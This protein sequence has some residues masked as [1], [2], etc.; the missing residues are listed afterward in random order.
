MPN[1]EQSLVLLKPDAVQRGLIGKI[2][3]RLEDRGL[4]I[5][6]LKLLQ[7]DMPL[8]QRHYAAHLDRPF[9]QGLAEFMS[10]APIVAMAVEGY[11]A[12][13]VVRA[14]M[15]TTDPQHATSGTVRGDFGVDIGRNLIHGSDSPDAAKREL[16]IFFGKDELLSY[17]RDVDRWITEP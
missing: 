8:A 3:T 7:M 5:V 14:T 13:D 17:P 4:K 10:S 16:G 9:F 2:I 12:V 6:G 15:G 1:V 11:N